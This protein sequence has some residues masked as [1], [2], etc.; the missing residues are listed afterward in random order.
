MAAVRDGLR[1]AGEICG[2]TCFPMAEMSGR[3]YINSDR[4]HEVTTI[5]TSFKLDMLRPVVIKEIKRLVRRNHGN[6]I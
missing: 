3:I 2:R 4:R 5:V 1:S 6:E